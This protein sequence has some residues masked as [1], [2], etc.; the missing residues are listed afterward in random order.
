[1]TNE[2]P[3][4][5]YERAGKVGAT[6]EPVTLVTIPAIIGDNYN[7]DNSNTTASVRS[8]G[9]TNYG[10]AFKVFE[11]ISLSSC[12]F[13]LKKTGSPTGNMTA[14][15]YAMTGTFGTNGKPTGAALATSSTLDVTTLTSSLALITFTFSTGY[16]L[17]DDT[18]YCIALDATGVTGDVNNNVNL[19]ADST[20]PS[21]QGNRLSSSD[22]GSSWSTSAVQDI[23]FY[24]LGLPLKYDFNG[25]LGHWYRMNLTVG[26]STGNVTVRIGN[27]PAT[28]INAGAGSSTLEINHTSGMGVLRI[29][30]SST[31]NGT[32]TAVSIIFIS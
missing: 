1:M 18:F 8:D 6:K 20:S 32:I 16:L 28:T 2:E 4:W 30:P 23:P 13:Y 19:G 15:L 10:Q 7:E 24:I 9:N 14:K 3:T 29:T 11:N 26:G 22:S 21:H 5:H 17:K 27:G 31:F 25:R 12:K